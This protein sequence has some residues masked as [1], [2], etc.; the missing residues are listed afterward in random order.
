MPTIDSGRLDE[1]QRFPPPRPEPT[2]D[3]PKEAVSWPKAP[4]RPSEDAELVAQG[5]RL[6]QEISTRGLS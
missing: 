5:Q 2:Q 4:I 3:Q 1:H 6:E